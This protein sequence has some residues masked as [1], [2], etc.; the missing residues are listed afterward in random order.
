MTFILTAS[1][2]SC[3]EASN[4]SPFHL[5]RS[6]WKF[7]QM[8]RSWP[9]RK[10]SWYIS[11]DHLWCFHRSNLSLSKVI[12]ENCWWPFMIWKAEMTLATLVRVTG[13]NIP[14]QGVNSNCNAMFEGVSNGFR[15]KEAPFNFLP[16]TYRWRGRKIGLILGHRYQNSET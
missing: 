1:C 2:S 5:K 14:I 6:S 11:V 7:D 4:E 10:R 16:L 13:R 12:S 3:R 8:W 15:S 9:D